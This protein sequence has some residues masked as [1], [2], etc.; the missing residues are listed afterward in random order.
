MKSSGIFNVSSFI[1][2]AGISTVNGVKVTGVNLSDN[3]RLAVTLVGNKQN[4]SSF[5]IPPSSVSVIVLRI[6]LSHDDLISLMTV[7]AASSK[8]KSGFMNSLGA[9]Q[10]SSNASSAGY[11][12]PPEQNNATDFNPFNFLKN[13]QIGSTSLVNA[14]LENPTYCEDGI[15]PSSSVTNLQT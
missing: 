11:V 14:G 13:I 7:A 5:D 12:L 15:L 8:N 10:G 9:Q 2:A 3:N 1:I 6:A 4:N